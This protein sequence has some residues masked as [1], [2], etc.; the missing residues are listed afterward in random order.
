MTETQ[1]SA[2]SVQFLTFKEVSRITGIKSPNT[3][4]AHEERGT[5]PR[6]YYLSDRCVRWDEAEVL[7]WR[8]QLPRSLDEL[9]ERDG[10]ETSG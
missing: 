8:D 2:A 7:V 10:N 9:R 1:S 6:R 5:F 3:L 4:K